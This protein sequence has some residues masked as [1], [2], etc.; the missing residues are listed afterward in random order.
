M[1]VLSNYLHNLFILMHLFNS[2]LHSRQALIAG[3]YPALCLWQPLLSKTFGSNKNKPVIGY[4]NRANLST[5]TKTQVSSLRDFM[6][7]PIIKSTS[8]P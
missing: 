7:V 8:A 6:V 2:F 4:S 1:Q 3:S 5:S